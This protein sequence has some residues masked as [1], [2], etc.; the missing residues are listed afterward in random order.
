M[1]KL[2]IPINPDVFMLSKVGTRTKIQS[3]NQYLKFY[4]GKMS[5]I[6]LRQRVPIW[7]PI[8]KSKKVH[9]ITTK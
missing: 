9:T 6:D 1:N 4:Y 7:T 8:L 5:L 3:M 2:V